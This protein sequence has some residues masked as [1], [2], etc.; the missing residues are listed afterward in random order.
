MHSTIVQSD[1]NFMIQKWQ[2][3]ELTFLSYEW[4]YSNLIKNKTK[5]NFPL[6]HF[7]S[8]EMYSTIDKYITFGKM[9]FKSSPVFYGL[10]KNHT[11]WVW[12]DKGWINKTFLGELLIQLN[13]KAMKAKQK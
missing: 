1:L 11:V 6:K 12:N 2:L 10:K 7:A 13:Q 8:K 4:F 9:I 3:H 5:P